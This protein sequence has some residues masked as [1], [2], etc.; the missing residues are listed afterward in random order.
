MLIKMHQFKV[1]NFKSIHLNCAA[2]GVGDHV[3]GFDR[4][5]HLREASLGVEK[6]ND[7]DASKA[8]LRKGGEAPEELTASASFHQIT[9]PKN[10]PHHNA[11]P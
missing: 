3:E 11:S 6:P 8:P 9:R 7:A 4:L 2:I 1:Q 10:A 5:G